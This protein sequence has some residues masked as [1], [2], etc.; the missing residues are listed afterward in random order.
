M[1]DTMK[2][3]SFKADTFK[4]MHSILVVPE[5]AS[6]SEKVERSVGLCFLVRRT[7]Q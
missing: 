2:I 5:M 4:V 1:R 3:I 6:S 7:G